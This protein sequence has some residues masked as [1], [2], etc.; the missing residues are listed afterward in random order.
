MHFSWL[1]TSSSLEDHMKEDLTWNI[2]TTEAVWKLPQKPDFL[3]PL[4]GVRFLRKALSA[5]T[6]PPSRH[7]RPAAS[8]W[9]SR[10]TEA[11]STS[12]GHKQFREDHWLCSPIAPFLSSYFCSFPLGVSAANQPFP[13]NLYISSISSSFIATNFLSSFTASTRLSAISSTAVGRPKTQMDSTHPRHKWLPPG[14]LHKA[15]KH[16]H[17][18]TSE[19]LFHTAVQAFSANKNNTKLWAKHLCVNGRDACV[20]SNLVIYCISCNYCLKLVNLHS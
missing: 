17:Y 9:F 1:S 16:Q 12:E 3:T 4:R 5:S 14:R 15:L 2:T 6:A 7:L 13:S 8:V 19:Q 20:C 11:L 18:W 10:C